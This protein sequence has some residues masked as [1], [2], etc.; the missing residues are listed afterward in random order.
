MFG[1]LTEKKKKRTPDNP[2]ISN[3]IN[4]LSPLGLKEQRQVVLPESRIFVTSPHWMGSQTIDTLC[5]NLQTTMATLAPTEGHSLLQVPRLGGE[6]LEL[7][8]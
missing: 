7:V 3:G 4:Q 1:K 2:N 6:N 8:L 5:W